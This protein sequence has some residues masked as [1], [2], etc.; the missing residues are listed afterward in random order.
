MASPVEKSGKRWK[1]FFG[2]LED[3]KNKDLLELL[4][5]NYQKEM[6]EAARLKSHAQ[7]LRYE[8]LRKKL[9][10]IAEAEKKHADILKNL[11]TKLGGTPP[12]VQI[13]KASDES[14]PIFQKLIEDLETKTNDYWETLEVIFNSEQK[15]HLEI[16]PELETIREEEAKLRDE[17]LDILQITNPY[18]L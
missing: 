17:L 2:E 5:E 15:G 14:K 9:I 11:I 6:A 10:E 8:H 7:E 12:E 18:T 1:N 3:P 13:E 4:Q 16:I